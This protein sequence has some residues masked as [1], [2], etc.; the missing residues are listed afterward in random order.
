MVADTKLQ[1]IVIAIR[2]TLSLA[3]VM[4]DMV[5]RPKSLKTMLTEEFANRNF[6]CAQEISSLNEM[7]EDIEVHAG[8]A[9]AAIFI[10]QQV[11]IISKQK[12]REFNGKNSIRSPSPSVK[13]Q[14]KL[15]YLRLVLLEVIRQNITG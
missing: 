4:T 15:V 1:K 13:I 5:A 14:I 9:E 7:A 6:L 11:V 3:D 10:F 8:M 12:T 2:G